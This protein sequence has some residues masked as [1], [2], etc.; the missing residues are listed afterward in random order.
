VIAFSL[1]FPQ[2]KFPRANIQC[3]IPL[4]RL[5]STQTETTWAA[6]RLVE[7][8]IHF[9]LFNSCMVI[10]L[11]TPKRTENTDFSQ[12]TKQSLG[13]NIIQSFNSRSCKIPQ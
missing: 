5:S 1:F 12:V 6:E 13:D 10:L 3:I 4:V 11:F 8:Y 9:V 2:T 7:P